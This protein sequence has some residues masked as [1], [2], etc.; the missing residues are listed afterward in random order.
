MVLF[1]VEILG[2]AIRRE[3]E[4][5]GTKIRKETVIMWLYTWKKSKAG[6]YSMVVT[7]HMWLSSMG[8]VARLKSK[9]YDL[10][11]INLNLK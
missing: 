11:L 5:T 8:N 7:G 2:N 4:N 6:L 10:I 1:M 9:S 3:E